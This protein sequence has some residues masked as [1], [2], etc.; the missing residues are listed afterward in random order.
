MGVGDHD[1]FGL[2]AGVSL[3]DTPDDPGADPAAARA[4]LHHAGTYARRRL[5]HALRERRRECIDSRIRHRKAPFHSQ[6]KVRYLFGPPSLLRM[7]GEMG[8]MSEMSEWVTP[9]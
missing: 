2:A 3:P 4:H 8:R 1:G 9:A 5:G 7:R 6:K